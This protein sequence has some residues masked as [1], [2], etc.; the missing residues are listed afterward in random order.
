MCPS[1]S[2]L[3]VDCTGKDGRVGQRCARDRKWQADELWKVPL[4]IDVASSSFPR[5]S[6]PFNLPS[7]VLVEALFDLAVDM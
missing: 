2:H 6:R 1:T 5:R 7:S 3:Q 4:C